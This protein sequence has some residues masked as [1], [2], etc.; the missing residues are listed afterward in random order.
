MRKNVNKTVDV[1]VVFDRRH[2]ATKSTV[3]DRKAAPIYIEVY[4]DRKRFYY[5]TGIKVH[6]DQF[7]NGRVY[8]CAQ[9][10]VYN[11]RIR[12]ILTT[13]EEYINNTYKEGAVF[14]LSSLKDYLATSNV[15]SDSSFLD[16]MENCIKERNVAKH[17]RAMYRCTFRKLQTWGRIKSFGDVT[18]DNIK[19]WHNEAVKV[20]RKAAFAANYDRTLKTFVTEACREGLIRENPYTKWKAPKYVPVQTHRGVS[21][22]DLRKLEHVT[23]NTD[24]KER[25]R[26][27]F[28]FQANTG[29]AYADTQSFMPS[30]LITYKGR[31]VYQNKRIKTNEPFYIPINK[32][33]KSILEKYGGIPPKISLYYYDRLLKDIAKEAGVTQ[34]ISSH[35]AR[36]TFAMLCVNNG[37]NI[38]TLAKLLGH[39][40]VQTTQVYAQ[41]KQDTINTEFDEVMERIGEEE[42]PPKP[43]EA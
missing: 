26:D 28:L 27:L 10:G 17:T 7:R 22:S 1:K 33:A 35:W 9:Q 38:F 13:I 25:A 6:T 12:L 30:E 29:L 32:K 21:L 4:Y 16:F 14:N 40:K 11:E 19:A 3:R 15:G 39:S 42:A 36:H 18:L 8:N 37:M 41:L 5:P 43:A 2:T 20:S 23:L 34:A 24:G 31:M